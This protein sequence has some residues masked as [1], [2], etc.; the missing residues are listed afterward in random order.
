MSFSVQPSPNLENGTPDSK[1]E[2]IRN[3]FHDC[4]GVYESLFDVM[5]SDE[6]YFQRADPLRHPLIFYL[7][8]TA[9]FFINK[10][11]LAKVISERVNPRFESIFA[12][13]VDEMSWDDLNEQN[14]KWP[15]VAEVWQYRRE[16]RAVVEQAIDE[17]PLSLPVTWEDPFWVIMMG[18]EHERIHIETSSVLMRQLPLKFVQENLRWPVCE[19]SDKA[20]ENNFLNVAGGQVILGKPLGHKYYGWDN[21]YGKQETSVTDFRAGRFLVSNG[22]FKKF[23]DAGGYSTQKWWSEEGWAWRNFRKAE[24]PVFWIMGKN[25][26]VSLRCLATEIDMPWNWPAEVNFLEAKAFCNWMAETTGRPVRLPSE[27]EWYRLLA[28]AGLNDV[29]DWSQAAGNINL[30]QGASPCP[31]NKY[32]TAGFGDVMGNVWQWTE[33]PISGFPGFKVHPLYDDFSTPTF[34]TRHNLFKGG[35]WISTGNEVTK[36]ARYAFRRHFFQHAG[37]RY[38]ESAAPVEIKNE[39]YETDSSVSQYCEF[40]YGVEYFG[41]PNFP[42]QVA[43]ICGELVKSRPHARALDLGCATGRSSFELARFFDHVTGVDFSARFIRVGHEMQQTGTILY[44]MAEEGE[45]VTYHEKNLKD[46]GLEQL[47]DKVEFWQGDAH[48][49]KTQFTDYDL[50]LACNLIDRLYNPAKFIEHILRRIKPGG[51]LVLL[52][53][54]TWLEE[55]TPKD[56]WL[57]GRKVDGENVMT[58][59]GLRRELEPVFTLVGDPKDVPF[60]IKETA[61]KFQHT[62]SQMT[63]WEKTGH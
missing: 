29:E 25:G 41:V 51:L 19:Q 57:G 23:I 12:I 62:V 31:V 7:G 42:K 63:V 60:V 6:A 14:Y 47:Q 28:V 30:S 39:V 21:E 1:R 38:I 49:L 8:H 10:M 52:S 44:T 43:E 61:R 18:I 22:E 37:F 50:V 13:G 27:A 24:Y 36:Y 4:W 40:H 15:T 53:P 58:L 2:E 46:F 48:N 55:F 35:S 59:D 56:N 5:A 9:T 20:P 3:Y 34:D 16:V 32:L 11:V 54:Y 33:T 26:K 45:L 17:L